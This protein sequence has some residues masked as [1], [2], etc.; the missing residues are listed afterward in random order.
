M[1][2]ERVIG[3]DGCR[4][5]WL[6]VQRAGPTI[7]AELVTDL[8][9][10]FDQVRSGAVA[11]LAI[12]M[13]IGLLDRQ[14]R[15]CDVEARKLLGPRRSSV[16]P[17]PIRVT[18]GAEDYDDACHRSRSASGKALSK[19]AFNLL[20]KIAEIDRL[21]LPDDQDRIVEA[22]PECAFVRLAGAPLES[23]KRTAEGQR[24]RERLL[25][26]ADPDLG[27]FV[28]RE[29]ER[30]VLPILDVIDATV[31]TVTAGHV[32]AGTERRLGAEIDPR[33]LRAEITY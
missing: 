12:D 1:T 24:L 8:A 23:A 9:P 11:A 10:L 31:L 14:P 20:P 5:G 27:R 2:S 17:A 21:V 29:R 6:V 18:L 19:Q 28:K 4:G 25:G 26:E 16:F 15:T 33:G 30:G 13:P 32:A 3:I 22:H 7:D